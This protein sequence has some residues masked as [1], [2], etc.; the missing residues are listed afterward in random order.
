MTG[1]ADDALAG[2]LAKRLAGVG[3]G[4]AWP[5]LVAAGVPGLCVPEE[6]GGLGLP[7]AAAAPVL[8]ALGEHGLAAP[9]LESCVI[10]PALL[11]SRR[12]G[13]GDA[14]LRGIAAGGIVAVAG[15]ERALRGAVSATP[16]G[17]GWRLDG[18]AKLVPDGASAS[19]IL[20]A[21]RTEGGGSALLIAG[22]DQPGITARAYPTIDDREAADLLFLGAEAT[23]VLADATEALQDA[24]DI[25]LACLATEA[26]GL[27]RGLVEQTLAHCRAR[28][29]F[30]QPIGR[31]QVVRHRLVDMRIEARRTGA[32]AQRAIEALDGHWRERGRLASAAKATAA[33]AG[34]FVGQAAVQLHGAMG[35]TR[36]LDAG[37]FFRR[38]TVIEGQMGSAA[39]HRQRYLKLAA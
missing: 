32:I 26:A 2:M 1:A 36:E 18:E 22:R 17:G 8:A 34:R 9:F 35:M 37:R 15:L 5:A 31:F 4:E 10:A 20:V 27:M 39:E 12:T 11:L 28:E 33:E 30:G 25:A 6:L 21:A 7:V 38:L 16:A 29:Q 19:A 13:A 23:P 3:P 14:L 24:E